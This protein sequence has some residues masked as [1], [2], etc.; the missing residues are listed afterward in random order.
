MKNYLDFKNTKKYDELKLPAEKIKAGEIVVF[1]TETVYAIGTNGFDENAIEKI[2]EVKNRPFN[3][4][5]SLL[6]SDLDM[7]KKLAKDITKEEEKLMKAFFPGPF[8]IVLKKSDLV[9]DVLTSGGDTVGI[10][11]PDDDIAL[12]LIKLA[13]VPIAAPSANITGKKSGTNIDDIVLD[14]GD[15]V[16]FYIDGGES[17]LGIGSTIVKMVDG[18]PVILRQGSISEKE[19]QDVLK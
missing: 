15:S 7:V 12:N 9:P 3:K 6:V 10:R 1:P 2:Y 4:P 11:M 5:I 14:F 18:I 19:I 13:G 17:K 8:T 16:D